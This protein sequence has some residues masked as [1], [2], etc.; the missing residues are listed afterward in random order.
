[1]IKDFHKTA[2]RGE[3]NIIYEAS[4]GVISKRKIYVYQLKNKKIIAY[5]YLRK[6]IRCFHTERILAAEIIR[7]RKDR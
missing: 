4:S 7:Q 1:M 3:W 2:R 6:Q 5:C